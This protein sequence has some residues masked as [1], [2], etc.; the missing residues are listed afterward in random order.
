MFSGW[1]FTAYMDLGQNVLREMAVVKSKTWTPELYYFLIV[2]MATIA[3]LL[4]A[5]VVSFSRKEIN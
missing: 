3:V 5:S 2:N 4:A 1:I